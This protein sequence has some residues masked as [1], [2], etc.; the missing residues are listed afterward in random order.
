MGGHQVADAKTIYKSFGSLFVI[1][2]CFGVHNFKQ[3]RC[4]RL[5]EP[6]QVRKV[7]FR[8]ETKIKANVMQTIRH[9]PSLQWATRRL[10]EPDQ[11]CEYSG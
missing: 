6:K 3:S 5:V 9:V 2:R 11:F 4:D 8:K 7:S 10:V 1:A